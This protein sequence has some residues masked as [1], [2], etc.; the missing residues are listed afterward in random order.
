MRWSVQCGGWFTGAEGELVSPGH[1]ANYANNL[2]CNYTIEAAGDDTYVVAT[3]EGVFDVEPH[4]LCIYDK[5][6]AYQVPSSK[7]TTTTKEWI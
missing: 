2:V 7:T 6:Q 1:P 4:S 3:F 5:L